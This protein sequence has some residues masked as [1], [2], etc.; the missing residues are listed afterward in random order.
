[1]P[2][3]TLHVLTKAIQRRLNISE[4]EAR[5]YAEIVMDMF[6]YDDCIIDNILDHAERRLF[7]RLESEGILSTRREEAI[8]SDGTNWRIRYWQ[9]QKKVI[10]STE[11]KKKIK[12][13]VQKS[14]PRPSYEPHTIYSSLPETAWTTRKTHFI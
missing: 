4:P 13:T 1:M 6:G 7:Y 9:F 2:L 11:P 8:L 10:F 12:A 3:I 14:K 5:G